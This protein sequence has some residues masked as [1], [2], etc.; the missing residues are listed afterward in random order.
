M[1]DGVSVLLGPELSW[2]GGLQ[3]WAGVAEQARR[4]ETTPTARPNRRP[5]VLYT[6]PVGHMSGSLGLDGFG[7]SRFLGLAPQATCLYP[8]GAGDW[9]ILIGGIQ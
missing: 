5:D 3:R 9:L 7:V 2:R 6:L 8:F 4:R 1:L